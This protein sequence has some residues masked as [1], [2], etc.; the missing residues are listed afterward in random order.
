M[1]CLHTG[2][3][4]QLDQQ[5]QNRNQNP[6]S[7]KESSLYQALT[8]ESSKLSADHLQMGKFFGCLVCL[9][10]K[11][12]CVASGKALATEY[13]LGHSEIGSLITTP[14][15]RDNSPVCHCL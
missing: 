5:S 7:L 11:C 14:P 2:L 12:F 10:Q 13:K 9:M 15:P 8:E 1:L 3:Q 6:C 4:F